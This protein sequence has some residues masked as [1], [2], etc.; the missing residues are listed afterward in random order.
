MSSLRDLL[1]HYRDNAQTE[2]EKGNYFE[3]LAVA[4]IKNDP[5]MAQQFED[6]WLFAEWAA[7]QGLDGRDTGIDAVA[8]IRGED[9][10]SAIARRG[11]GY[12]PQGAPVFGEMTV[13][14]N[15]LLGRAG[16]RQSILLD[17]AFTLFPPLARR[18]KIPAGQLS[19]GER[20]MLAFARLMVGNLSLI[21]L[22]EP[23]SGL[24]PNLRHAMLDKVR[25]W[26][27]RGMACL[28]VEQNI[29]DVAAI[30]NRM[31]GLKK[32][33]IVYQGSGRVFAERSVRRP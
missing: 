11:V 29:D 26:C 22:D 18:A 10:P 23:T 14:Q 2:R 30:S 7:M 3:R 15:I 8:K 12:F 19:G 31:Y 21:L 25:D 17:E 28:I 32:G 1:A 27:S 9:V 24:Q 13:V 6:C 33:R 4:F 5:G 20:H 16:R